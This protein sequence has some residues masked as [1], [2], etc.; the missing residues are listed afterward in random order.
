MNLGGYEDYLR[1]ELPPLVRRQLEKEVE[2]EL[3]FVE[4]GMKQKVIDIARN[5]QLTLFKGYQQLENQERGLQDTPSVDASSSSETGASF[6]TATDTSPSTMTTSGTTPEIPDPLDIFGDPAIPD[7]DFNFLADVPYPESQSPSKGQNMD[8][9]FN[10]SF[11]TQ[12]P[13]TI[14]PGME[15][16]SAQQH[17]LPYYGLDGYQDPNSQRIDASVL[18]YLP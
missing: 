10:Q 8:S 1:R 9:G 13:A 7:F 3:S 18:S 4:E 16:L 15:M 2:R 11:A 12:E 5:L 6:F 17:D 14:T